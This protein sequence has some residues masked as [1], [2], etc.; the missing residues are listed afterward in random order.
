MVKK[1]SIFVLFVA[2]FFI[3]NGQ[4]QYGSAKNKGVVGEFVCFLGFIFVVV[5][6]KKFF[7][8]FLSLIFFYLQWKLAI[9]NQ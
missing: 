5:V 8:H 6:V 4:C 9:K 2:I 3:P 7:K 1:P